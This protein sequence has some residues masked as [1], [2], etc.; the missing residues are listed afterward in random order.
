[1]EFPL[2]PADFIKQYPRAYNEG[3]GPVRTRVDPMKIKQMTRKD[4]MPCRHGNKALGSSR[5]APPSSRA[6]AQRDRGED[7]SDRLLERLLGSDGGTTPRRRCEKSPAVVPA[8]P[9]LEDAG[10]AAA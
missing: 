3:E 4:L 1:M 6:S 8:L 10:G 5:A 9:P 2:D 7:L